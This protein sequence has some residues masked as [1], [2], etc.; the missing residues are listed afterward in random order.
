MLIMSK[1]KQL[2]KNILNLIPMN[3]SYN[4]NVVVLF[5]VT[6][7]VEMLGSPSGMHN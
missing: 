1:N 4:I 7:E 3:V 5:A 2:L 6:K